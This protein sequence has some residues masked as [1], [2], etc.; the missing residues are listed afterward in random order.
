[1]GSRGIDRATLAIAAGGTGGHLFPG[2]SVARAWLLR[3]PA[4]SVVF[5]HQKKTRVM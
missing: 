5:W 2:L 4:G 3:H 1:M